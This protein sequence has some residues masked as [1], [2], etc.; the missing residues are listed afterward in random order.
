VPVFL[1]PLPVQSLLHGG[2]AVS[3]GQN[4]LYMLELNGGVADVEALTQNIVDPPQDGVALRWRHVV[5][6][7]VATECARLRAQAPDVQVVHIDHALDAAQLLGDIL[8]FQPLG[9]AL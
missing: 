4:A 8:Q 9:Q 1:L 7:H 5:N 6:Q 3:L 2:G